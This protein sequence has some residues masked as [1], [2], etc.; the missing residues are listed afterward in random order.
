MADI[1]VV[2]FALTKLG[3]TEQLTSLTQTGSKLASLAR[4]IYPL[5]R[6]RELRRH[7]WN[8][9]K[10]QVQLAADSTDPLFDFDYRY[11]K[12]ADYLRMAR[13][14]DAECRTVIGGY[15]YTDESAPLDVLYIKDETDTDKW[16][17]LFFDAAAC[18]VALEL[19]PSRTASNTTVQRIF[20]QYREAIMEA[21][22]VNAIELPPEEA[23]EDSWL[24]ARRAGFQ[25]APLLSTQ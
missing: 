10:V 18:G 5:V 7:T 15:I 24:S 21:R 9:A 12:P 2:N 6:K 14:V 16:D 13:K 23:P 22:R 3:D 1:D 11:T 4:T 20:T 8:F 17:P 25:S 19:A